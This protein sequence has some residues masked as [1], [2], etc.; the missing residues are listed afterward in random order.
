MQAKITSF[1]ER[2]TKLRTD[3]FRE[4]YPDT[5]A[6]GL[7]K[8]EITVT[9]G[10]KYAKLISDNSVFCFVEIATGN[11]RKAASFKTP[12]KGVRGNI[13]DA[14]GGM[15]SVTPYGAVYFR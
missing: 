2:V 13:T 14:S 3:Y 15:D 12:A 9:F 1:A 7:S 8:P 6:A 11:V 5:F 10:A 4:R